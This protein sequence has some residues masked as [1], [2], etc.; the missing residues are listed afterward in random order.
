M[1]QAL[2]EWWK[3]D[4]AGTAAVWVRERVGKAWLIDHF[5]PG[6]TVDPIHLPCAPARQRTD[7]PVGEAAGVVDLPRRS[8]ADHPFRSWQD[9]FELLA[10]ASESQPLRTVL[11]EFPQLPRAVP[12]F[13][14]ELTALGDGWSS[15]S[16]RNAPLRVGGQRD[17][18]VAGGAV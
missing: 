8:L 5:A 18:G 11:D 13:D 14:K 6:E 4:G 1:L 9:A 15:K 17:G 3:Q 7:R 2:K 16:R 10:R 12:G